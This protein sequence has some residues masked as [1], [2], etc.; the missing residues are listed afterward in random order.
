VI[1]AR[2]EVDRL[3]EV[4]LKSERK[5]LVFNV[6]GVLKNCWEVKQCAIVSYVRKKY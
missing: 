3:S 4:V 6:C 1:D 2:D 5:V